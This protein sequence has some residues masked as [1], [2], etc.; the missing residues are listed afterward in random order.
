MALAEMVADTPG[1]PPLS[2]VLAAL[3]CIPL[4]LAWVMLIASPIL[5]ATMRE[6]DASVVVGSVA[7]VITGLLGIMGVFVGQLLRFWRQITEVRIEN[8]K[9]LEAAKIANQR[10]WDEAN[11]ESLSGQIKELSEN[12]KELK[13]QAA[14]DL[15]ELKQK[16]S[17]E[18]AGLNEQLEHARKSLHD[19]RNAENARRLTMEAEHQQ[20]REDLRKTREMLHQRDQAFME[21]VRQSK[22]VRERTVVHGQRITD[23]EQSTAS[24]SREG[25]PVYK[26]PEEPA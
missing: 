2:P 16:S 22:E 6:F 17:R 10:A 20:T 19:L 15:E 14:R 24:Q 8:E 13:A 18:A 9:A 1:R 4:P 21:L 5:L 11:K 23:L 25:I 3:A 26:P 12:I 7:A